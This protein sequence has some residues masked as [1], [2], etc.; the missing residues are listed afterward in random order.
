M[1]RGTHGHRCWGRRKRDDYRK[2]PNRK[3][4]SRALRRVTCHCRGNRYCGSHR[5]QRRRRVG[6]WNSA[7][8]MSRKHRPTTHRRSADH[9]RGRRTS[10]TYQRPVNTKSGFVIDWRHRD[11]RGAQYRE[12]RRSRSAW[13]GHGDGAC[14]RR[15]AAAATGQER[16]ARE[17]NRERRKKPQH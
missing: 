6:C 14:L 5:D 4:N 8:R 3:H 16:Y 2:T 11:R 9:R 13:I 17:R 1:R 10:S 15:Q 12:L 7:R